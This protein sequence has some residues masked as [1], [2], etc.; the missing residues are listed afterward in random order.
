MTPNSSVGLATTLTNWRAWGDLHIL[1][2]IA[3]AFVYYT[4]LI[5][6]GSF[7]L[8]QT[9][10]REI[11]SGVV[12][13]SMLSHLLQGDFAVDPEAI[14]LEA[15]VRDGKTYAYFGIAPAFLRLPLL[16]FSNF[17]TIDITALSMVIATCVSAYFKCASLQLI[18]RFGNENTAQTAIYGLLVVWILLGGPQ[19][20]FLKASIYQEVICWAMALTSAFIYCAMRGLFLPARFSPALLLVMAC[21]AGLALLTRVTAG[22]GL[23]GALGLLLV[24]LGTRVYDMRPSRPGTAGESETGQRVSLLG[25]LTSAH[26]MPPLLILIACAALCGV[27]NYGRWGNPFVFADVHLNRLMMGSR[28]AAVDAYG[29]FN[30]RRVPY[31]LMYYFFPIDFFLPAQDGGSLF[32]EVRR[33]YY[34][35]VELPISSFLVSD[36]VTLILAAVFVFGLM[37]GRGPAGFDLRSAAAL[38][39][40]FALPVLLILTYYFLAF[41]FRGEFYP[42]LDLAALLG[43]HAASRFPSPLATWRLQ[44]A[45]SYSVI[46]GISASH[47]LLVAYKAVEWT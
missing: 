18:K 21:I 28:I 8:F 47:T 25:G 1:F 42:I 23:Y 34:D 10:P 43:F 39:A 4:L 41:R 17:A 29:E 19:V 24:A 40:G 2:G 33:R 30:L 5:T 12:F 3:L 6:D 11:V 13:N 31:S 35:G 38:F 44:K 32:G 37:R 22:I 20:Q 9:R 14:R 7:N 16:P 15:F 26:V 27:V 36:P 45:V 46:V